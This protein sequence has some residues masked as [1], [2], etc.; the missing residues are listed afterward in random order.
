MKSL[1]AIISTVLFLLPVP[2]M[3]HGSSEENL[4]DHDPAASV[5]NA[6]T[7]M[8]GWAMTSINWRDIPQ[9]ENNTLTEARVKL[10]AMLFFDPRLSGSNMMSCATCH[11]PKMGFSD[12]VPLFIGDHG[13]TGPRATPTSQNLAWNTNFFWDGRAKSLEEQAI[14]PIQ[15]PEEMNQDLRSLM[16]ELSDAGYYPYFRD[17]FGKYTEINPT[18]IGKALAAYQRTLVSVNSP[19]DRYMAG[20]RTAMTSSQIRGMELFQTKAQCTTCHFGPNFTDDGFHNIGIDTTDTGRHKLLPLP[21]MKYA[22]KTP[23]LRDVAY[24]APYFHDGSASTLEEVIELYDQGGVSYMRDMPNIAI[25]PLSLTA[26]EKQDL[27]AFMEALS[28]VGVYDYPVP[29]LPVK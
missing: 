25:Q 4:P 11:H 14:M 7:P 13:N 26:Q 24:R 27:V 15:S 22:F 20:D 28:G 21:S 2:F 12:G 6:N 18:N 16:R 17:A 19:F 1:I 8:T 9:P 5:S 29:K 23:G 10:G 3:L